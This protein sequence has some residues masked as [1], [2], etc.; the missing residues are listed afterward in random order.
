MLVTAVAF[1]KLK[2]HYSAREIFLLTGLL[3]VPVFFYVVWLLPQATIR[4]LVWLALV[5]RR[6]LGWRIG[7]R[8]VVGVAGGVGGVQDG[9]ADR[10]FGDGQGSLT[11]LRWRPRRFPR[12]RI[13]RCGGM[14]GCHGLPFGPRAPHSVRSK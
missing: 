9:V 12:L 8:G 11:G 5:A 2:P 1:A 6:R 3:T 4:F 10:L 7:R 14:L 13:G